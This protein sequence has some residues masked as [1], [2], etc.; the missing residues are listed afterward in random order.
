MPCAISGAAIMIA[1]LTLTDGS[2]ARMIGTGIT[3]NA[4]VKKIMSTPTLRSDW[5]SSPRASSMSRSPIACEM[6]GNIAVATDTAIS[7]YGS[8]YSVKAF[9]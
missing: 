9:W 2:S 4:T 8:T 7:E 5:L 6:R 1:S 3:M